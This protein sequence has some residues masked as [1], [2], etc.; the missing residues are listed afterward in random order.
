MEFI[1][2]INQRVNA[3]VWG[4]PMLVLLIGTGVLLT[5]LTRGIQFRRFGFAFREVFGKILHRGPGEGTVRPFQALATALAST[6]GVGNIAG[7]STAIHLGGPGALFWLIVSGLL[8]MVTKFAEVAVALHYRRPDAT[9]TVRGGAMY[10]LSQGLGLPWLG[11]T[12]ALLTAVAAFG[13][14]NMVQANSV[15]EAAR[16]S[17]GVEPRLTG[18]VLAVLTGAVILGGLRRIAEVTQFLVPFMCIFYLVGGVVVLIRFAAEIPGSIEVM[19][20]SVFT[21]QAAIGGFAGATVRDA[22]SYGLKRG[23][24]A[25][26][27]GLG[28]APMV[29]SSAVTDHPIRQACY[30]IVEVFVVTNVVCTLTGLVV[31]ATGAWQSGATGAELSARAFSI[32]LPGEWGHYVVSIGLITFAL[33]T[34]IGWSYYGETAIAY[35]AGVKAVLPYRLL[36]TG[37]VYLG[38]VGSLHLLW[39]IADTLNG[40]MAIPN[41]IGVLGSLR[42]LQRLIAEFFSERGS[43]APAAPQ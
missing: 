32:G 27:A 42:L 21:G 7:V 4:A 25:N 34:L 14:G 39:E 9:G 33:S 2:E 23:L 41:L 37:F 36:W 17:F 31:L 13:I 15:A 12:F 20:R 10:V 35:L 28:S 16:T 40:L 1:A 29:H 19:M 38:A 8:G 30:G 26:E 18:V 43:E 5:V 24:F 11:A 6:V 3:V 22:L